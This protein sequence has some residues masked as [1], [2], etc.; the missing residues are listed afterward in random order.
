MSFAF[1]S[2]F[3]SSCSTNS[4][5][6]RCRSVPPYSI[7]YFFIANCKKKKNP[8]PFYDLQSLQVHVLSMHLELLHLVEM[9]RCLPPAFNLQLSVPRNV[10]VF[11]LRALLAGGLSVVQNKSRWNYI[12]HHFV[13]L[14]ET[15]S[16]LSTS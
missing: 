6:W 10:L 5:P 13:C 7:P 2:Y 9:L 4:L 1:A 12:G 11:F 3:V 14:G 16:R 15:T 8:L